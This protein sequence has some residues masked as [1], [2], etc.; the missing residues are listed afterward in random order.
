[1]ATLG[2]KANS[3][4]DDGGDP[5]GDVKKMYE[6]LKRMEATDGQDG[7]DDEP[8]DEEDLDSDDEEHGT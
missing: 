2:K 6:I 4:V 3:I 5:N 7:F 8:D 1:M